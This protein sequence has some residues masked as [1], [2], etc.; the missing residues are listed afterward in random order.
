MRGEMHLP[1]V[2]LALYGSTQYV[3]SAFLCFVWLCFALLCSG[4]LLLSQLEMEVTSFR[5][6][7]V[8]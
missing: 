6:C 8:A 3:G 5:H 2:S 1:L 4:L 7:L